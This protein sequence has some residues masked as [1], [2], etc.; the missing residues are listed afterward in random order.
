MG[1]IKIGLVCI[2]V[3]AIPTS[4]NLIAVCCNQ[5]AKYV[6]KN[7]AKKQARITLFDC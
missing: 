1:M 4:V 5:I 7:A 2:R 3:A 6:P